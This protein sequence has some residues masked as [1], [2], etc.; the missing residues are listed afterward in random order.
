LNSKSA[1]TFCFLNNSYTFKNIQELRQI[2][3][4]LVLSFHRPEPVVHGRWKSVPLP[5]ACQSKQI[6]LRF[7]SQI[8]PK[9]LL[10]KCLLL[11]SMYY[12]NENNNK[13]QGKRVN[14]SPSTP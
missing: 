7:S 13:E 14:L 1:A 12:F 4:D 8:G 5:K 3:L 9:I 2:L 6:P 10:I 11:V